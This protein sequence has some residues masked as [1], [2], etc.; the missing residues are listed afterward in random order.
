MGNIEKFRMALIGNINKRV[1][2]GQ[3]VFKVKPARPLKDIWKETVPDQS[4]GGDFKCLLANEALWV[5]VDEETFTIH[6]VLFGEMSLKLIDYFVFFQRAK[7]AVAAGTIT[8]PIYLRESPYENSVYRNIAV[9]PLTSSYQTKHW[10]RNTGNGDWKEQH[11]RQRLFN[12]LKRERQW[13]TGPVLAALDSVIWRLYPTKINVPGLA[14]YLRDIHA[15]YYYAQSACDNALWLLAT[16]ESLNLSA[17]MLRDVVSRH[18]V[19]E[20]CNYSVRSDYSV[21]TLIDI[22]NIE[23]LYRQASPVFSLPHGHNK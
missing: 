23:L 5:T 11:F 17:A 15:I 21:D 4:I 18:A 6:P 9:A 7:E 10:Q 2:P 8:T 22:E 12:T 16:R 20:V 14:V 1:L 19:L 13:L 3:P